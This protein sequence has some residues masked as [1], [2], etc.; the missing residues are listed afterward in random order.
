MQSEVFFSIARAT[1]PISKSA[2]MR[3][4][5]ALLV[6]GLVALVAIVGTSFWL[7]ER[8]QVYFEEVLEAREARTAA[9]DLRKRHAG[10]RRRTARLFA[11][12]R[13]APP[14]QFLFCAAESV[15]PL[16]EELTELLQPYP[17]AATPMVQF[18]YGARPQGGHG[19]PVPSN[20]G[21]R[22][23]IA[24]R[25]SPF[26]QKN[27]IPDMLAEAR[28]FLDALI[29]AADQRLADGVE[30]Q[31]VTATAPAPG[32][33]DRRHYRDRGHGRYRCFTRA[34]TT[35]ATWFA[36]RQEVEALNADLEGRVNR[37]HGKS[38]SGPMRR[39]S[40]SPIS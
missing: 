2:F 13:R 6:V 5:A 39:S 35:R 17:Q 7:V 38:S 30:D 27:A 20:C 14:G 1:M 24:A 19:E 40:A 3:L 33:A 25:P 11:D 37:A 34:S 36:A 10:N 31:R 12:Q 23:T 28:N 9:V 16:Y 26:S 18:A 29:G 8:T 32:D 22:A 4:T 15:D 21:A